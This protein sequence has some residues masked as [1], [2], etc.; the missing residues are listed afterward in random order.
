VHVYRATQHLPASERYGLQSQLRRAAISVPTNIVEGAVRHSDRHYLRYLE[1]ALG[2]AC[3][4]RYLLE[5]CERLEF[6][7]TADHEHLRERYAEL[8]GSMSALI[9]HINHDLRERRGVVAE[10]SQEPGVEAESR[11]LKAEG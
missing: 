8:I 11:K 5:L 4:V 10:N 3:E 7:P 1:I 2:S 6:L 9:R